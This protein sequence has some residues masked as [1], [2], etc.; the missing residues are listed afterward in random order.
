MNCVNRD[1]AEEFCKWIGGQLPTEAQWEYAARSE[2][3][4]CKYPWNADPENTDSLS[5]TYTVWWEYVDQLE[6]CNKGHTWPV[7][8]KKA[9]NTVQA[10]CDMSGNVAEWVA[11]DFH[12][13]YEGAPSDGNT[14]WT[15][16]ESDGV[17]RGGAWKTGNPPYMTTTAR[18]Y[19]SPTA[20]YAHFGFRC[21][22]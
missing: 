17:A 1:G 8:S 4:F 9:G 22:K 2:G 11:D 7:C 15:N 6:G 18:L 12:T 5:C 20:M 19:A 3:K 13:T 10:L 14:P 16:G 21:A